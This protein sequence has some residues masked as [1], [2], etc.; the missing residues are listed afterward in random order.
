MNVWTREFCL[1]VLTMVS[2][3]GFHDTAKDLGYSTESIFRSLLCSYVKKFGLLTEYK[4]MLDFSSDVRGKNKVIKKEAPCMQ[5]TRDNLDKMFAEALERKGFD[6][7]YRDY[8]YT[9]VH[10]FMYDIHRATIDRGIRYKINS[11]FRKM[12]DK[13]TCIEIID[14]IKTNGRPAAMEKYL[15]VPYFAFYQNL[16]YVASNYGI[17]ALCDD[18]QVKPWNFNS[19]K[20]L[21]EKVIREIQE[22][23]IDTVARKY[24]YIVGSSGFLSNLYKGSVI[25]GV[26]S[27]YDE[28]K[29]L[30]GK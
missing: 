6:K 13:R 1:N 4:H 8:G 23:D 2:E 29:T 18:D 3:R 7:V 28:F 20:E 30:I 15:C 25:C 12:W 19:D 5:W 27:N 16:R 14:Y 17:E 11:T 24:G 22:S 10:E 26:V 21:C 9:D